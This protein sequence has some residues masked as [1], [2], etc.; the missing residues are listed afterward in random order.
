[1][2]SKDDPGKRLMIVEDEPLV[3]SLIKTVLEALGFHV[4]GVASSG[5]EALALAGSTLPHLV[6]L[7]IRLAGPADGVDIAC[8]LRE[9]FAIPAIFLSGR[10]DAATIE[11]ARHARPLGFLRKPFRPSQV[12]DAIERALNPPAPQQEAE[13]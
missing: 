6:L 5:A 4:C 7:D 9:R 10:L 3:A 12:F 8:A 13:P 11:R 2:V 1:M